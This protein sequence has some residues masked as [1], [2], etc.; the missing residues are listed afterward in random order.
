MPDLGIFGWNVR[1]ILSYSKSAPSH[2]SNCKIWPEN[3]NAQIWYQ[4][5]FIWIFLTKNVFFGYVSVRILRILVPYLK[6]TSSSLS[7]SKIGPKNSDFGIFGWNLKQYCHIWNQPPR[8]CL[9]AK[10]GTKNKSPKFST[11]NALFEYFQPK[12][13]SLDFFGKNCEKTFT[14]FE[15]STLRIVCSQNFTKKQ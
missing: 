11:K 2:L 6:S 15:I 8:N 14:I 10:F 7:F 5:S 9:I 12:S 3:K 13:V 1:I 4:K